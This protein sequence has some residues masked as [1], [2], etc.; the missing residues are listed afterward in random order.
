MPAP[1]NK[2]CRSGVNNLPRSE[3]KQ[4]SFLLKQN[5]N[6]KRIQLLSYDL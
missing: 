2:V 6:L 1:E 4:S 5:L 3:R